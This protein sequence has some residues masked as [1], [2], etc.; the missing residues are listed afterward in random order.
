M[1]EEMRT[2]KGGTTEGSI[3]KQLAI[4][5]L[6]AEKCG[7]FGR[8]SMTVLQYRELEMAYAKPIANMLNAGG[9][10]I[11]AVDFEFMSAFS[12]VFLTLKP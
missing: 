4:K 7:P 10:K 11:S 1:I 12:S 6:A 8:I 3:F 9:M 5:P 2:R